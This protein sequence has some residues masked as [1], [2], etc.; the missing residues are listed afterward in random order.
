MNA[1]R[2]IGAFFDIDGTLLAAPSLEWRFLGF[3][4]TRDLVGSRQIARWAAQ[5]AKTI[6]RDPRAALDA[7]KFYLAGLPE[8]LV[9]NW[10]KFVAPNPEKNAS[11]PIFSEGFERIAW[12][13]SQGH[14]IFF[15]SGTIEPLAHI[16]TRFPAPQGLHWS[17]EIC[18][19]KLET[20]DGVWTGRIIG[21]HMSGRA[22]AAAIRASAARHDLALA[23]SYAYGDSFADLPMLETVGHPVAVNPQARLARIA[24]RR[25]WP[26]LGWQSIAKCTSCATST[27]VTSDASGGV[28]P[29]RNQS[30]LAAGNSR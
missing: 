9:Q 23:E 6:R 18:A 28:G 16:L 7:N 24:R 8:S 27:T 19:T 13:V 14:R 26:V 4:L 2:Q 1:A 10:E 17:A 20:R 15:V 25:R 12:H 3:L 30:S 5:C 11:L 22:K 21:E 29:A